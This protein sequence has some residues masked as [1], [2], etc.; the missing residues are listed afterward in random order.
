M[1]TE[2]VGRGLI[3]PLGDLMEE[4]LEGATDLQ[5]TEN[6]TQIGLDGFLADAELRRPADRNLLL[7]WVGQE[8]MRD[9][10]SAI[11]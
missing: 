4:E 5:L 1:E 7:G 8:V 10:P 3:R 6:I 11:R 2:R 9:L